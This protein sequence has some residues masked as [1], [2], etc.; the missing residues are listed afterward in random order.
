LQADGEAGITEG[1]TMH[2]F[3]DGE[4]ARVIKHGTEVEVMVFRQIGD[5]VYVFDKANRAYQYRVRDVLPARRLYT[6]THEHGMSSG[7]GV[8]SER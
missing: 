8:H 7:A 1:D 6:D 5:L 3:Q 2:E 4:E